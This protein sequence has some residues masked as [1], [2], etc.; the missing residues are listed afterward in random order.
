[1]VDAVIDQFRR[2]IAR[3]DVDDTGSRSSDLASTRMSSENVAENIR[4]CRLAGSAAMMRRIGRMNPMS[5]MRSASSSTSIS[6]FD[7]STARDSR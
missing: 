1:M 4:L 2:R 5:S 6:I 3:R 7:R